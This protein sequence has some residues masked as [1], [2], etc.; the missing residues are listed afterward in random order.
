MSS[1]PCVVE[2]GSKK[3]PSTT[4]DGS[5]ASVDRRAPTATMAEPK[6]KP[7]MS[8][9]AAR[10]VLKVERSSSG[11]D[12]KKAYKKL[13]LKHHPDKGGSADEFRKVNEAMEMCMDHLY[14]PASFSRSGLAARS[15]PRLGKSGVEAIDTRS[16]HGQGP[17][18][19]A[20]HLTRGEIKGDEGRYSEMYGRY[21]RAT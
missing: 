6:T 19:Q 21:R 3:S 9:A 15:A 8:L 10:A 1:A 13:A 18:P 7:T 14:E 16:E 4:R 11:E 5:P 12:V 2:K 17:R 20:R